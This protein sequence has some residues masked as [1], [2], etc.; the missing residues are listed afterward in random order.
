MAGEEDHEEGADVRHKKT[1]AAGKKNQGFSAEEKAAA[2][3]RVR[4]LK[5]EARR[6]SDRAAGEKDPPLPRSPR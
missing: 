2:R 1:A 3:E 5:A 4:E 6:G